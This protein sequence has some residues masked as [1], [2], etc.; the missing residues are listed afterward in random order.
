MKTSHFLSALLAAMAFSAVASADILLENKDGHAWQIAI[1][2]PVSTVTTEVPARGFMVL[3]EGALS[4]QIRDKSGNDV[5]KAVDVA[6]GDR[7]TVKNGRLTRT[8]NGA[9]DI[10]SGF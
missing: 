1:R 10:A 2:H 9:G 3:S 8:P 6:D 4:V 5:G 7:V